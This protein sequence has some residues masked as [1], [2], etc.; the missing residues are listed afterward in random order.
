MYKIYLN[1]KQVD[2]QASLCSPPSISD[3]EKIEWPLETG[4]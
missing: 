3:N 4:T 1:K 2:K